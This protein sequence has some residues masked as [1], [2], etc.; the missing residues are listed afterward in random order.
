MTE[1][2]KEIE[3]T[4]EEIVKHGPELSGQRVHLSILDGSGPVEESIPVATN[5]KGIPIT[6]LDAYM[7]SIPHIENDAKFEAFER[8]IYA[9]RAERRRIAQQDVET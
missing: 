6:D 7:S 1:P 4:W 5:F 2:A 8:A 9:E 3:G